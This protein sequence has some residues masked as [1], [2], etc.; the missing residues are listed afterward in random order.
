MVKAN[1][2]LQLLSLRTLDKYRARYKV[3]DGTTDKLMDLIIESYGKYKRDRNLTHVPYFAIQID[4][5]FVKQLLSYNPGSSEIN[6]QLS[7]V[8]ETL[9]TQPLIQLITGKQ[10]FKPSH[11]MLQINILCLN[12]GWY[13]EGPC[14]GS[15]KGFST[16]Q[17]FKIIFGD[18][19][20]MW[21]M[22]KPEWII[23]MII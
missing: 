7:Q 13:Y 22:R 5:M 11:S 17:L 14:Y 2:I 21:W 8:H 12:D 4:E 16:A 18:F 19:L 9:F 6:G 10:D 1:N 23:K 20:K 15:E 3:V